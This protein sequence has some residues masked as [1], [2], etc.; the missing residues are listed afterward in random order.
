M[1][2]KTNERTHFMKKSKKRKLI[3]IFLALIIIITGSVGGFY[4][5]RRH[6][7]EKTYLQAEKYFEQKDYSAAKKLFI[8]LGVYRDSTEWVSKCDIQPELDSAAQLMEQGQYEQAREIFQKYK[9]EENSNECTYQLAISY[10]DAKEYAKSLQEFEKIPSYK[11]VTEKMRAVTYDYALLL[12]NK[13]QYEDAQICF[14][15]TSDYKNA[16]EFIEKCN[17]GIKY[18]KCKLDSTESNSYDNPIDYYSAIEE[19]IME[20]YFYYTWYDANNKKLIIDKN[21]INGIPYQVISV[22]TYGAYPVLTFCYKNEDVSHE[23][24]RLSPC[25][26]EYADN[27]MENIRFDNATYYS[28]K[29]ETQKKILKAHDDYEEQLKQAKLQYDKLQS[30]NIQYDLKNETIKKYEEWYKNGSIYRIP[31]YHYTNWSI[32]E[33][34]GLYVVEM[35]AGSIA[36]DFWN[37]YKVTATFSAENNS[38]KCISFDCNN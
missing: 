35:T 30:Q 27:F 2:I 11:D 9:L 38:Y 26:D 5:V 33:S 3:P 8:Q 14:Q 24:C 1:I 13:Q 32:T 34:N 16:T 4:A 23:I 7:Q 19:Q 18:E 6:Q 20:G 36:M 29:G 21:T 22:E 25:T 17:I 10:A 28:E 31:L 37:D 12:Y 15:Y